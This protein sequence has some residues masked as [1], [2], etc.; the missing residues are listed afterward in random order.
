MHGVLKIGCA[1]NNVSKSHGSMDDGKHIKNDWRGFT[2][3]T[4]FGAID[5]QY[6]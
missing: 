1:F 5:V 2:E 6:S 4:I 3:N